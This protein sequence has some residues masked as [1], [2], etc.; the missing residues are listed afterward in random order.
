M[1]D[2]GRV[3]R[4]D[5]H[6]AVTALPEYRKRIDDLEN[7]VMVAK[8]RDPP[9]QPTL[10]PLDIFGDSRL[11]GSPTLPHGV[12]PDII[13]TRARDVAT[14]LGVD[15]AMVALPMLVVCAAAIDDR[16]QIIPLQHDQTWKEST[17][18]WLALIAESGQKKTPAINAA[19][20]PLRTIEKDW[21]QEDKKRAEEYATRHAIHAAAN[22]QQQREL[23]KALARGA[24]IELPTL[25]NPPIKPPTRRKE[26]KDTTVEALSEVFA[27][28]SWG[29]L[30]VHDE[31]TSWFGSF[32]AY[33]ADKTK[34]DRAL[35]LE[36]YNGGGQVIDRISRGRVYV[37]NWSLSLIGGIQPSAM[38]KLASQ[39]TD[40]GLAQRFIPIFSHG[41]GITVDQPEN[42]L[43]RVRYEDLVKKLVLLSPG[44]PEARLFCRFSEAAATHREFLNQRI[45]YVR[46][47][48]WV[49]SGFQTHLSKWEGL[50]PRL[51]LL[52]HV[53]LHADDPFLPETI[54][55]ETAERV[56]VF[57]LDYL[58]PH[59][60]RFYTELM[61]LTDP[62]VHARWIAGHILAN[63]LTEISAR[64]IGRVYRPLRK[65]VR[66]LQKAMEQ[67][68]A[69][70]WVVPS[71]SGLPHGHRKWRVLP[72]VHTLFQKQKRAEKHHRAETI[73]KIQ[74]SV[75]QFP[76]LGERERENG[77]D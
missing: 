35:Y 55:T 47:M 11:I 41:D 76:V 4:F 31:L 56:C 38:Q 59:A 19:L 27:D 30:A 21:M 51:C 75:R 18:L 73:R 1:E 45:H 37:P 57:M 22:K 54:S 69:I 36:A 68:T 20:A 46:A 33:R 70:A 23:A 74:E 7:A 3:D 42:P 14:R 71:D 58:L 65:D 39:L 77:Q 6:A 63:D 24:D 17:R 13:E 50:F 9:S 67:L 49:T 43:A 15:P 62:E 48:P 32:D 40:D 72:E 29:L 28:N 5:I 2:H 53:I 12:L 52:W 26:V 64:D 10:T 61:Q 60:A 44:G 66:D 34:K 8:E 16:I 25:P